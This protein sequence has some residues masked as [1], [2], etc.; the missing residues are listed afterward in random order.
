MTVKGPGNDVISKTRRRLE[1]E[2]YWNTDDP[3]CYLYS[4]SDHLIKWKGVREH[5]KNAAANGVPVRLR[6]FDNSA[7]CKH[8][9]EDSDEYLDAV[10]DV[11]E[12]EG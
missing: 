5:A 8:I 3:R 1:D 7:H 2:R 6:C 9:Q 11:W 12:E 10:L 4:K